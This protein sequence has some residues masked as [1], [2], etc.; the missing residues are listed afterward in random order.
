MAEADP[1]QRDAAEQLAH[2]LDLVDE[3]L[4]VA[5]A[6]REHHAVVAGELVGV[7]VCGTTVT[8]APASARRR[9][10]ERFVP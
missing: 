2:D 8:A 10:I 7:V 6:V 3:R 4:G 1:E 9:A 5:G